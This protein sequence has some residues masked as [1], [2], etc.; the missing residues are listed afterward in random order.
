MSHFTY[1]IEGGVTITF[2]AK[3][4][5]RVRGLLKAHGFR[6]SKAGFWYRHKV[7]GSADLIGHSTS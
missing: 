4:S 2:P 3:P 5:E 1:A 7:N 6:W